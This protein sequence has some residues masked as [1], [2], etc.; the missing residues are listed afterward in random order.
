MSG[1]L[2]RYTPASAL[3]PGQLECSVHDLFLRCV[4]ATHKS[5]A[6]CACCR[7]LG[8]AQQSPGIARGLEK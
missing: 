1:V 7:I 2:A 8:V 3:M 6:R 5:D 4:V